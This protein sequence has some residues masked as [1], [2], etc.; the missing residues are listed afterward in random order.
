M[1]GL[2]TQSMLTVMEGDTNA[3]VAYAELMMPKP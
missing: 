2:I 1:G 3:Q